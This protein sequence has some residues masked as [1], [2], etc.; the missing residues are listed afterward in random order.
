M[1]VV[2][3]MLAITLIALALLGVLSR[4]LY[5]LHRTQ[6][7]L[8]NADRYVMAWRYRAQ[9]A[10]RQLRDLG[11]ADTAP[12]DDVIDRH[13][14][15]LPQALRGSGLSSAELAHQ[16]DALNGPT[17]A[18]RAVPLPVRVGGGEAT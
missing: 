18:T 17:V 16:R 2:G 4:A 7:R 8:R 5:I 3:C 11:L 6:R 12:A 10:Q 9:W 15:T 1:F 13:F 14:A